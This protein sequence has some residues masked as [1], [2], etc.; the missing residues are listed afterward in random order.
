NR[1]LDLQRV[2]N[3]LA[4]L[5]DVRVDEKEGWAETLGGRVQV[6]REGGIVVRAADE[7]GAKKLVEKTRQLVVR[8]MLCVG[9]GVCVGACTEGAISLEEGRA[10]VDAERC[11][12]C[13]R[14]L[15]RCP[16]VDFGGT[17][18]WQG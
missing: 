14:C 15:K 12:H 2:A 13:G 3:M 8:A 9:C 5:G 18:E 4:I 1:P 16:V 17:E 7:D 10:Y 11:T 6:F